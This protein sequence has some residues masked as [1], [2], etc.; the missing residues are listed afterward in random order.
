MKLLPVGFVR[1]YIL[2]L[3]L[4]ATPVQANSLFDK[5]K[6]GY[7]KVKES[8]NITTSNSEYIKEKDLPLHFSKSWHFSYLQEPIF[9]SKVVILEAGKQNKESILLVHGLGQS[10][11]KDWF[12]VI[13]YLETNYH[14]IAIDLPGFGYSAKPEGRFSPTNYAKILKSISRKVAKRKL[15]VMGHSMGGAVSLRFASLAPELIS[16]LILVDAAG[17]LEKTAFI[18]SLGQLPSGNTEILKN[19]L[20]QLNDLSSSFIELTNMNFFANAISKNAL[21]WELLS[22]SPNVNAALSLVEEDF[23]LAIN[24][25]QIPT[26]IIWGELDNIAPIR[27]GKVLKHKIK[28]ANIIIIKGA[29]HVPMKSHNSQFLYELDKILKDEVKDEG[30]LLEVKNLGNLICE[31]EKNQIYSGHFDSIILKQCSNIKLSNITTNRLVIK[32]SLVEIENLKLHSDGNALISEESVIKITNGE[33]TGKNAIRL[34]GSRLD[35]AGMNIQSSA[36]SI[37]S[38]IS[39]KVILSISH[40]DS[41]YYKGL[42]HGSF[43]LKNQNIDTLLTNSRNE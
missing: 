28:N 25:L 37:F 20:A 7:D 17:I 39:S 2:I 26:A 4:L 29:E 12:E 6:S 11:M 38:D 33:I 34:S 24:E 21:T 3:I 27:A 43:K 40:I 16:K 22:D 23:S 5:F 8:I 9:N 14:V 19:S 41:P 30:T 42:A 36:E 31:N 32:G 13:P 10:G 15:I 35:L 1:F 18:K